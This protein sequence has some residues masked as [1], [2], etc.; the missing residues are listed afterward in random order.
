MR[1]PHAGTPFDTSDDEIAEALLDVSIPTLMLSLVHLSGDPSFIRGRIKPA[2]L[3]L[4]EVQGYMPEEDKAEARALAL[5]VIRDYRDRRV[6]RARTDLARAAQGD[7]GV[8]RRRGGPRRVRADAARGDGARRRRRPQGRAAPT[9]PRPATPSPSSSSAAAS[10]ACSPG[11]ACKE[12]GHPLHRH[13]EERRRG[14]HLVGEHLPRRPRRRRQPLLLL[15]LRAQR[16]L[17]RVL[18]AAARAAGLLPAASW[19]KHGIAAARPLRDR[20]RLGHLGRRRRHLAG[21]RPR[22]GRHRGRRCAPGR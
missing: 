20:G 17:D 16:P 15:Q 6:P 18:R 9:T 22:R 2:G 3:F 5:E 12:A 21:A 14:R 19:T 1:N 7:D 10:P 11:S 8:A 13:R 4:N